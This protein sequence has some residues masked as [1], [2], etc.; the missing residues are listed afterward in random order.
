MI[1]IYKTNYK[2]SFKIHQITSLIKKS[3]TVLLVG[4]GDSDFYKSVR[5]SCSS[6]TVVDLRSLRFDDVEFI[7]ADI[8]SSKTLKNRTFDK[9]IFSVS[10]EYVIDDIAALN[11]TKRLLNT[12]GS[13]ILDLGYVQYRSWVPARSYLTWEVIDILEFCGFKCTDIIPWGFTNLFYKRRIS[14]MIINFIYKILGFNAA[15]ELEKKLSHKLL[16]VFKL[17]GSYHGAYMV[18]EHTIN[19]LRQYNIDKS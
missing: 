13:L 16:L 3:D 7:N 4:A 5:N 15:F 1:K 10:L 8:C 14:R 18:A 9:I 6:L 11:N 12:D 19:K 2:E 17:L